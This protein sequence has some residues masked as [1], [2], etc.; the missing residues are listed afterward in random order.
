M[1]FRLNKIQNKIHNSIDNFFPAFNN[2]K[3][4]LNN[5]TINNVKYNIGSIIMVNIN[6]NCPEFEEIKN[7]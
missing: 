3:F 4:Y 6:D 1:L 7:I 2:K 5:I